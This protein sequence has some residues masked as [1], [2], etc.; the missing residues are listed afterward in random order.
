VVA[1]PLD[2]ADRQ[3]L[4]SGVQAYLGDVPLDVIQVEDIPAAR[5]GKFQYVVRETP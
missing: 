4:R 5:S 1:E 2:E 3:V